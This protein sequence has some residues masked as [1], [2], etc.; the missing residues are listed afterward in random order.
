VRLSHFSFPFLT[1]KKNQLHRVV[2]NI[3]PANHNAYCADCRALAL[4][5]G[6]KKFHHSKDY[7]TLESLG[8][9]VV[10]TGLFIEVA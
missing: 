2:I 10:K 7:N 1:A 8:R 4:A 5:S 9:T 3:N 6:F